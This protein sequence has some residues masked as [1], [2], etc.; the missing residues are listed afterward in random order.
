MVVA[1]AERLGRTAS[2][3]RKD[4]GDEGRVLLEPPPP[5]RQRDAGTEPEA[6]HAKHLRGDEVVRGE[7]SPQPARLA[8]KRKRV[9]RD[10]PANAQRGRGL[11][12]GAASDRER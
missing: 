4:L 2:G 9:A 8:A 3:P 7:E 1:D 11:V 5:F 6:L 12:C 10:E